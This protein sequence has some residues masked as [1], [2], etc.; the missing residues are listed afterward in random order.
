M[1]NMATSEIKAFLP[2]KDYEFSKRFY[3]NLIAPVLRHQEDLHYLHAGPS[4]FLV[5]RFY[6]KEFAENLMMHLLVEDVEAW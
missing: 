2:A 1:A 3:V 6:Q 5:S 4:S